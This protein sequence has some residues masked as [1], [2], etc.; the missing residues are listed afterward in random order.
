MVSKVFWF[1]LQQAIPNWH[2]TIYLGLPAIILLAIATGLYQVSKEKY[3][4]THGVLAGLSLLLTTINIVTIIPMTGVV[5][6]LPVVDLFHLLHIIIGAVGYGFGIGA[7]ITGISGVRTKIPGVVAL[8]CWTTVFV[9]GYI[10]FL[11]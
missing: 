6:S 1:D 7:F 5:L 3:T 2:M 4:F 10:Q 8:I 9:M 11:L